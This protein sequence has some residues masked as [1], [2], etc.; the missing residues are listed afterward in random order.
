M[1]TINSFHEILIQLDIRIKQCVLGKRHVQKKE[2]LHHL[3]IKGHNNYN[4]TSNMK[5]ERFILAYQYQT[6]IDT[7]QHFII[8][9]IKPS[10]W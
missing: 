10:H 8:K 6:E 2:Y 9:K 4:S 7:Y 5:S 3:K 1:N